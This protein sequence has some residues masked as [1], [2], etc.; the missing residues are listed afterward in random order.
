MTLGFHSALFAAAVP[1]VK[2]LGD[3][4]VHVNSGTSVSLRCLISNVLDVPSYV[5][6][7]HGATRLLDDGGKRVSILTQRVVGEGAAVSTLTIRDPTPAESG[8]YTC[9][10]ENLDPASV[11]LHV[12]R[13]EEL[14][15][16]IK[17]RFELYFYVSVCS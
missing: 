5:F 13:G 2:I 15:S 16:S 17:C 9:R 11:R 7:H 14:S 8:R 3:P 1:S 12:I 6:W 4:E 10:P